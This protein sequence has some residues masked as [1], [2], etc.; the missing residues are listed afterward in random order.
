MQGDERM[1]KSILVVLI[2]V[3]FLLVLSPYQATED[4]AAPEPGHYAHFDTSK[5][6]FTVELNPDA[7]PI[8]VD[9]FEK[10]VKDGFYDGLIFHRVMND[11]MIQGGGFENDLT[12]KEP[13]YDPIKNEAITSGLSNVEYTIAMA[14]TNEPDTAT[15]Q[16]FINTADNPFLDPGG[17]SEAGYCVFGR[18][19]NGFSVI[20][21]IEIVPTTTEGGHEYVP[22]EDVTIISVT[23]EIIEDTS[24]GGSGGTTDGETSEDSGSACCFVLIPMA[25][26]IA[27][28]ACGYAWKKK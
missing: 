17:N 6:E 2:L 3:S 22:E 10:Y 4:A 19:T 8:T 5:G 20:D 18:V 14:R 11:F 16:F 21:N 12:P 27:I 25:I 1:R 13:L 7:A 9:N 24:S 28:V 26:L 15:S 23:I